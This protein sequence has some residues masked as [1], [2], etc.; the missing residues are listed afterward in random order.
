MCSVQEGG[1]RVKIR[2]T[3]P[4]CIY[5]YKVFGRK[6]SS[7]I[8]MSDEIAS[9]NKLNIFFLNQLQCSSFFSQSSR[10]RELSRTH[11]IRDDKG[12]YIYI[13]F[14]QQYKST[15]RMLYTSMKI[16]YSCFGH[17]LI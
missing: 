4:I 16:E 2:P 13:D 14:L 15:F 11:S 7:P 10:V 3:I 1:S 9:D 8:I 5:V 6:T 17:H 12:V